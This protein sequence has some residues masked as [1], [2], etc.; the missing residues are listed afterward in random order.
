MNKYSTA[1]VVAGIAAIIAGFTVF[2]HIAVAEGGYVTILAAIAL[3]GL[4]GN[5]NSV[6]FK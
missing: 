4:Y 6:Y 2:P 5:S 3:D 1:A